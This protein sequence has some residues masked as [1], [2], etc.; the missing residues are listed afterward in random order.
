MKRKLVFQ[1]CY[2]AIL[3]TVCITLKCFGLFDW[4]SVI[5]TVVPA[6]I[7]SAGS[8]LF[9]GADSLRRQKFDLLI[10]L[11][12]L[13]QHIKNV[14]DDKIRCSLAGRRYGIYKS[15][16]EINVELKQYKDELHQYH[17]TNLNKLIKLF[18][19][20]E[21]IDMFNLEKHLSLAEKQLKLS[22]LEKRLL[23]EAQKVHYT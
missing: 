1:I 20:K 10:E 9:D 17:Q 12:P 8:L 23:Q 16:Q 21:P 4:L 6:A 7:A 11:A 13:P 22:E 14:I 3:V 18:K 5:I 19:I 15:E 2:F